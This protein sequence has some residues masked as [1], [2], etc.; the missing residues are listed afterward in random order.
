MDKKQIEFLKSLLSA[1]SPSGYERDVRKIWREHVEDAADEVLTDVMGNCIA[2]LNPSGKPKVLLAGHCDEIGFQVTHI[3]DNGYLCFKPIGG[4]DVSLIP[5]RRVL[6]HTNAGPIPGVTG[7]KAIH[8]MTDEDRKKIPEIHD[9]WIDIGARNREEA[10]ETVRIGD[11][12]THDLGYRELRNNLVVSRALDDRT[13]AFVAAETLL[14]CAKRKSRL[15]AC[16]VAVAT[17]QEEVGLRGAMTAAFGARPDIGICIDVTHAT[18]SP[19]MDQRKH[20][21]IKLGKGPTLP[22]GGSVNP[23]VFDILSKVA[24]EHDLPYQ[25]DAS[26][27]RVGNDTWSL[28]VVREGV[29]T[30][31]VGIPLR[32]MH[33]P[34]EVC[35]LDDLDS[36]VGILTEFCMSLNAKTRIIPD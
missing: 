34:S 31:T 5:G 14:A 32:Y 28:Q 35:C 33:T 1:H 25:P 29:A 22:R 26:P 36:A 21:I 3:D 10:L 4:H 11:C 19:G 12:V 9:L 2:I 6:V 16:V 7:K 18:D 13:G 8:L 20:G 23:H 17:V 27:G 15:K 24:K 30:G